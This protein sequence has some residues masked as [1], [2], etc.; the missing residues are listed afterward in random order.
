MLT[1]SRML[2]TTKKTVKCKNRKVNNNKQVK[3]KN[4]VVS[5]NSS[6]SSVN[7]KLSNISC[8]SVNSIV[9]PNSQRSEN[10][11]VSTHSHRSENSIVSTNIV[12]DLENSIV[13]CQKLT[14]NDP[15]CPLTSDTQCTSSWRPWVGKSA[16]AP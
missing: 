9:S 13:L 4:K 11:I 5:T 16:D 2:S 15:E 6:H 3:C 7:S 8:R 10:S 12:I 14:Y 1:N